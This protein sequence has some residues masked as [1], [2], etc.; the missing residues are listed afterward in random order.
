MDHFAGRWRGC[1]IGRLSERRRIL[2]L[3]PPFLRSLVQEIVA[4]A[5]DVEVVGELDGDG[6]LLE[7]AVRTDAGFVI[8]AVGDP[9][10]SEV[11]LDLLAH[12]PLTK[13]LALAGEGRDA[14]LWELRPERALLGEISSDRLLSAIRAPDWRTTGVR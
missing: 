7:A 9:A 12:R 6:E 8:V 11:Q 14:V 13:V 2:V 5:D 1:T 4:D 10:S 3:G